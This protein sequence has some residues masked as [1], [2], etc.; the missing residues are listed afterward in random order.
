[1][2]KIPK[3]IFKRRFSLL[4]LSLFF[5]I[6]QAK[7]VTVNC[8]NCD[9]KGK[10]YSGKSLSNS[11]FSGADL[12]GANFANSNLDGVNFQ[13]AN[14]TDANF[15]K[16]SINADLSDNSIPSMFQ[17]ANL[18][19]TNFT[20]AKL[21]SVDFQYTSMSCTNFSKINAKNAVFGYLMHI[22]DEVGC[23]TS[24]AK[25]KISCEI[26]AH[27]SEL[28][29]TDVDI[30][31][32]RHQDHKPTDE[33][34]SESEQGLQ[35]YKITASSYAPSEI[36]T[37]SKAIKLTAN[38]TV[39]VNPD[40][41]DSSG[42]GLNHASSCKTIQYASQQCSS[43]DC[44]V[45]VAYGTYNLSSGISPKKGGNQYC[46]RLCQRGFDSDL[47]IKNHSANRC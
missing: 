5:S 10:D 32:C 38:Q 21:N 26:A 24:F 45:A 14:L 46:R 19:N 7:T 1:M 16:A 22:N 43:A 27:A 20:S 29:L 37:D 23:K 42:C 34:F 6:A 15:S 17:S 35:S 18:K 2:L 39:F 13:N 4:I 25:A 30:P 31:A 9:L 8:P 28:D 44:L 33:S 40:G 3:Y 12:T 47:S 11:N 41:A 36:L